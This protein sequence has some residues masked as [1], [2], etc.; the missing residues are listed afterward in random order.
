M[1][2]V[3]FSDSSSNITPELAAAWNVRILPLHY[4]I[5][6]EEHAAFGENFDGHAF[7][8]ALRART[9][10]R[11]SMINSEQFSHAFEQALAEGSDVL[12]IGMSSGISG[13]VQAAAIAANALSQ[14]Y[15]DRKVYVKD[16]LAASFG[17][18]LFVKK[19]SEMRV[20]GS[21]IDE[22]SAWI[23]SNVQRMNQVFT[24]DDLM[25]LRMGGRISGVSAV[26]G[27]LANVKPLL[28]GNREGKIVAIDRM[29]GRKKSL[30][31]MAERFAQ[32][33]RDPEGQIIAIAHS[34]C[35][36]DAQYLVNFIHRQFPEQEI[37]VRCYEPGTG[38]HVGPGAVAL[39][40]FGEER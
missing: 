23:D 37:L 17:E 31:A 19:A 2:F 21:T 5:N 26:L 16:T 25:Y 14:K 30:R 3:L 8:D 6:G 15:P 40:F 11:T 32:R 20:E 36:D 28:W 12:Y 29:I 4:T 18:G 13:T 1:G 9:P 34:D 35:E 24:V 22:V 27:T 10:V 7:Y 39:F 33:V 38:S